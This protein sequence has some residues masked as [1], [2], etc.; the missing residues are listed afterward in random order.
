MNLPQFIKT[1]ETFNKLL[2]L[3]QLCVL[4]IDAE[5]RLLFANP[6]F[7]RLTSFSEEAAKGR[8]LRELLKIDDLSRSLFFDLLSDR[9]QAEFSLALEVEVAGKETQHLIASVC[10]PEQ[11][12]DRENGSIIS[13]LPQSDLVEAEKELN[14]LRA[15][16]HAL[17]DAAFDGVIVYDFISHE[18]IYCNDKFVQL[19]G[20]DDRAE[21]MNSNPLEFSPAFQPDGRSS[22]EVIDDH[23]RRLMVRGASIVEYTH[24]RKGGQLFLVQASATRLQPPNQSQILCVLRDITKQK[25]TERDLKVQ[26]SRYALITEHISDI[27]LT[28]DAN[29]SITYV[30]P[31]IQKSLGYSPVEMLGRQV[32]DLAH[33]DDVPVFEQILSK[34]PV[35]FRSEVRLLNASSK[36]VWFEAEIKLRYDE[37]GRLM[38]SISVLRDISERKSVEAQKIEG[39]LAYQ[40]LAEHVHQGL[41]SLDAEGRFQFV[42]AHFCRLLDSSK[43]QVIGTK[44]EDWV[45]YQ[46][47]ERNRGSISKNAPTLEYRQ[48]LLTKRGL[49]KVDV[50]LVGNFAPNGQLVRITALVNVIE[51][52]SDE[53]PLIEKDNKS[54]S[55]QQ[56]DE[57]DFVATLKR[58]FPQ[59]T[60][61]D[62]MHCLLIRKGLSAR[63]VALQTK[64]AI[65]SVEMARYR[66][67]KKIDLNRSVR[68]STLLRELN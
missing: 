3:N 36:V 41:A 42:N 34:H 56:Q 35:R 21:I 26:H 1:K 68:L 8:K 15:T 24:M 2:E 5:E 27:I 53:M 32:K 40:L 31:S 16:Y 63:E 57:L 66:I 29:Y 12:H 60:D 48:S 20:A 67:R 33:P 14:T 4:S 50:R 22:K 30:S 28:S 43:E 39:E 18:N 51:H 49:I 37:K 6:A 46:K 11:A 55:N 64:I 61:Q 25:A 13:L 58:R 23:H 62:I 38:E 47:A 65:K 9:K 54:Y 52:S 17:L 59:L 7:Y 45:L 10:C 19:M 44:W